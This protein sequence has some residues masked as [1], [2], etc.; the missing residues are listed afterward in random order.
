M[1][2]R[3]SSGRIERSKQK[4]A[5][6][7]LAVIVFAALLTACGRSPDSDTQGAEPESKTQEVRSLSVVAGAVEQS[8]TVLWFAR[9]AGFYEKHGLD[10][11][12]TVG[13][14]NTI[15]LMVAKQGDIT[16]Y[17]VP[18]AF[19][20]VRNGLATSI[21]YGGVKG[22]G[23]DFV[24][25]KPHIKS[26][27]ECTRLA[28]F[29]IGSSAYGWAVK[30]K[31]LYDADYAIQT[32]GD[33]PTLAAAFSSG[34]ADCAN[35]VLAPFA[36]LLD[37][38]EAHLIVD[39][40]DPSTLPEDFPPELI[41][42]A[43]WGLKDHLE[44]KRDTVV[45][46]LRAVHEAFAAMKNMTPA[47]IAELL[48]TD[49]DWQTQSESQIADGYVGAADFFQPNDGYVTKKGFDSSADFYRDA[50]LDFIDPGSPAFS[51]SSMVDMSYYDAAVGKDS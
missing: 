17:S 31:S 46:F 24:V 22:E 36:A 4:S 27:K 15:N 18:A 8:S 50:G 40:R 39:P 11:S 14:G 12:I 9:V 44:S 33:F 29:S 5:A 48:R 49:R 16:L 47:Q 25:A 19:T 28:T 43:F 45:D 1:N 34:N 37:S 41:A 20:P 21:V 13:G 30:N 35:A 7:V 32:F 2:Q 6:A 10:V 23:G 26:I 51:Y 38:G 42:S 3:S